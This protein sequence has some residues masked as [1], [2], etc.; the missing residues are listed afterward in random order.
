M[1]HFLVYSVSSVYYMEYY[2]AVRY[3]WTRILDMHYIFC[4]QEVCVCVCVL[5]TR[6]LIYTLFG[7]F[8]LCCTWLFCCVRS[9]ISSNG[10]VICHAACVVCI[11]SGIVGSGEWLYSVFYCLKGSGFC[12]RALMYT[13]IYISVFCNKRLIRCAFNIQYICLICS[14]VSFK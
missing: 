2:M 7:L 4:L 12:T 8:L 3:F 13:I 1:H 14:S 5:Y 11:N 6:C 9:R 10:E